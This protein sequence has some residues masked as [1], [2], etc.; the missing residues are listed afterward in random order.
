MKYLLIALVPLLASC[1][2]APAQR[3]ESRPGRDGEVVFEGRLEPG[4]LIEVKGVNGS[5]H[6][7]RSND[8]DARVRVTRTGRRDDPES[9]E[10][11]TVRNDR[12]YTICA[13]PPSGS[14]PNVCAPGHDGRISSRRND[15]KVEFSVE[16]PAGVDLHG[17]I[18]NGT[19]ETTGLTGEVEAYSSKGRIVVDG[20]SHVIARTTNGPITL[21]SSGE[22][23]A[24][25]TNGPIHAD[26][27]RLEP[28]GEA[29]QFVSTN[30][31]VTLRIPR[32]TNADLEAQTT[33]G[34]IRSDLPIAAREFGR[35]G[36][37]GQIGSGGRPIRLHTTNGS[38]HIE[39]AS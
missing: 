36:V 21:R 31:S 27:A 20:G 38:I 25:T 9:V 1:T 22:G 17:W 19:I 39:E 24:F 34:R 29:L 7:V 13:L 37:R 33:N 8:S 28:S 23:S 3:L 5:I 4:Q 32:T 2:S 15:V 10:L 35:D 14:R 18:S 30:G 12:G 6:A 11:V 16:L 26:L